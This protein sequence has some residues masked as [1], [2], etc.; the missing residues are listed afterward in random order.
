MSKMQVCRRCLLACLVYTTLRRQIR[1]CRSFDW[2]LLGTLLHTGAL[3]HLRL[4][5]L[6][7]KLVNSPLAR[8]LAAKR[9]KNCAMP[10][11]FKSKFF[12]HEEASTCQPPSRSYQAEAVPDFALCELE[13]QKGSWQD[14]LHLYHT[15]AIAQR[16][17]QGKVARISI[18]RHY[19]RTCLRWLSDCCKSAT[20][21]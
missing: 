7:R 5:P 6:L 13:M 4:E 3:S 1:W 19:T 10:S 12:A 15:R 18:L 2:G 8:L 17:T 11:K 21:C 16:I 9:E 14:I 20:A